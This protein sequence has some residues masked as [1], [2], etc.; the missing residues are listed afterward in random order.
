M[1]KAAFILPHSPLLI[2]AI[3]KQNSYLLEQTKKA[4]QKIAEKIKS[5]KIDSVIIFSSHCPSFDK[6]WTFNVSP[7]LEIDFTAFGDFATKTKIKGDIIFAHKLKEDLEDRYPLKLISTGQIDYGSG[8]PLFLLSEQLKK[9]RVI[10]ISNTHYNLSTHFEFGKALQQELNKHSKKFAIIASGDLSHCLKPNSPGG[11]SPR[12]AKFDNK[13]IEYLNGEHP[14]DDILNMDEKMI[15]EAKACGLKSIM[16][17]LGAV[18]GITKT[19]KTLA[20]QNELGVGYLTMEL[21]ID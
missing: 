14:R 2:P 18:D 12:A 21:E 6:S 15:T 19:K 4:Y 8:V 17:I 20:Y 5:E 3:G 9:A 16:T 1:I 10:I 13:L 11:Y 7:E